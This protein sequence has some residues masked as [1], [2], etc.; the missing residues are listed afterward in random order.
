M[1]WIIF[2]ASILLLIKGGD[3]FVDGSIDI[4]RRT[5]L[6]RMLI[7]G[8]IVSIATTTPE[9]VASMMAS[10]AG[11]P[12]LALGNALGSVIA[13]IG[14]IVGLT[15]SIK[16]IK[17]D[18]LSFTKSALLMLIL[19]FFL[20]IFILK[21]DL[22]I[23]LGLLLLVCGIYYIVAELVSSRRYGAP[24]AKVET[25]DDLPSLTKTL[26]IFFIGAAM[27]VIGSRFL[28]SSSMTI[29]E[30]L[31]IPP[32]FIGLTIVALGTSLPEL[33]TAI[34]SLKKN[35]AD[36]S[37]G[38][39]IGANILCMT[40]V[41]GSAITIHP[42][43]LGTSGDIFSLLAMLFF[44]TLFFIMGRTGE[45]ISRKEGLVLLIS[46]FAY[47]FLAYLVG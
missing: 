3:F 25:F 41:S 33:V 20:A 27:I 12:Q 38:N 29:A 13:N 6:P 22:P 28:V 37:L 21:G 7:G 32:L 1:V 42:L 31:N 36:L 15:A 16:V 14:L 4:A 18:S 26:S 43:K 40:F 46:Y 34:I 19:G 39:I 9:L 23:W 8:T 17:V 11:S 47:V 30:K 2:L 24:E 35:V 45:R 5:G 44:V 10:F